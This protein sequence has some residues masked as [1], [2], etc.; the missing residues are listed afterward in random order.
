MCGPHIRLCL[1]TFRPIASKQ[2]NSLTTIDTLSWFDGEVVTHPLWLQ[3]VLGLIPGA[4]KGFYVWFFLL[5]LCFYLFSKNH[6]CHTILLFL[7]QCYFYLVYLTYCKICD[8]LPWYKDTDLASL[9]VKIITKL[10]SPTSCESIKQDWAI[11][12]GMYTLFFFLERTVCLMYRTWASKLYCRKSNWKLV[13]F[14]HL[15]RWICRKIHK[16]CI[17]RI[18]MANFIEKI[19]THCLR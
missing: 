9:M 13:F 3:E 5:L 1:F 16:S 2:L 8:R 7:L 18:R 12:I 19:C 10:R 6:F 11:Y 15:S 14:L 4:G 17:I